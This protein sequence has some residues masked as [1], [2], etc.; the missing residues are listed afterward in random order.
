MA[1]M[2]DFEV[3]SIDGEPRKLSDYRGRVALVVNVASRCGLTP[4]YAGLQQLYD[5]YRGRGLEVLGFPCNQFAAQEPG[6]DAEVKQFCSTTYGVDFPM[7]SKVDVNGPG[8]APLYGWLTAEAATPEG[9]GDVQWNF[10]KFLVGRDGRVAARF[11][12]QTDPAAPELV[13]AIEKALG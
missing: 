13:A 10:T 12:P 11:A 9:A 5:S 1:T 4:H 6:S 3:R 7:F 8:R 2:H